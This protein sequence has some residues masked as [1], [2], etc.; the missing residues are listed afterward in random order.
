MK[1]D[2]Q[3]TGIY[4]HIPFCLQK[5][6][7]CDFYSIPLSHPDIL[8]DYTR[9]ILAELRIR[10]GEAKGP[11][12]S[13]Y[14]GGGTPSLLSPE[15]LGRILD[16]VCTLYWAPDEL[17]ITLEANPATVNLQLLREIKATGINR[18]SIGIQSFSDLE[19]RVLGR[20]HR[21]HDAVEAV[22]DAVRAGF[23][24]FNID[25]IFGVPGQNLIDWQDNLAQASRLNP[26]HISAY[27]LQLD[28]AVPLAQR[29]KTG[30]LAM[31]DEDLEADLYSH[32]RAYLEKQGYSHY[33]IS[34]FALPG[35]ECQHNRLY[36]QGFDYL[37]FGAGGVSFDGWQRFANLPNLSRYMENL[38]QNLLPPREILEHMSQREK[39]A[40]AIITG[41]RLTEGISQA[42]FY[43]RF[44]VDIMREYEQV[45]ASCAS[46][47]LLSFSRGRLCL[48]PEAY[49][50]SNQVLCSFAG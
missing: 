3:P 24:N 10:Q 35:C 48:T 36:W 19:L 7:Y 38:R 40:D 50:L 45:I 42:E 21:A 26:P 28:P 29:I 27:L 20:R 49:F 32:T 1:N 33:E 43:Q 12:R 18:V 44:G 47:G 15:Q 31:L 2:L 6:A 25:L 23:D 46:Q 14:M 39:V 5:C 8:E 22:R 17:E 11:L 37:G 41:L 34:N 16:T 4:I 9:S 30:E 13:I